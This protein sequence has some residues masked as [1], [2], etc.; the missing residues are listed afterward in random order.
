[1]TDQTIPVRLL[2]AGDDVD[3]SELGGVQDRFMIDGADTEGRFALVQHLFTAKALAAPMH[4]HRNEDEFTYVLSGQIGAV[5]EGREVIAE[6]GDLLFKPRGQWHTFWNPSE[7]PAVCLELISP[8]G[9]EDLF[10]SFT[11][12]TEPPTP[13]V[14]AALA[15]EYGCE[16]DFEKTMPLVERLGLVF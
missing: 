14:L 1:M 3:Q 2:A 9:L 10:R 13:E 4:R 6:P 11:S 16:V 7:E 5:I 12:L 15:A 8:A